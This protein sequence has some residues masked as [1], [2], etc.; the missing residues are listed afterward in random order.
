M[1]YQH[2]IS[3]VQQPNLDNLC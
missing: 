3:K 1:Y 2:I